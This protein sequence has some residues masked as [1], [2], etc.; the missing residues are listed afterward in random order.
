[1]EQHIDLSFLKSFTGGDSA[2][3]KKYIS[4]FT[5]TA[6]AMIEKIKTDCSS[7]D[8]PALKTSSHSIKSQLKYM[9]ADS[10]QAIAYEIEQLS[11]KPDNTESLPALVEKLSS[12]CGSVVAELNEELEKL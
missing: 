1:M 8:W 10:A 4:M 2:K 3:M 5:G 6:P 11:A 7:G 12:L 9:G